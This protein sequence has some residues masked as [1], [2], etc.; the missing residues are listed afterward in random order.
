M[1]DITYIYV[2]FG[3]HIDENVDNTTRKEV[4]ALI[5]RCRKEGI[6]AFELAVIADDLTGGMMIASLLEREGV[7]CPVITETSQLEHI[8]PS[9][10]AVVF[11]NKFRLIPAPQAQETVRKA[12]EAFLTAGAKRLYYKYCATFDSTDKGNI[13]PCGETLMEV[14]GAERMIFSPSWPEWEVTVYQGHMFLGPNL[15]SNTQKIHDPVTPM[16]DSN[17]VN[18]LQRQTKVKVGLLS[19]TALQ[20]GLSASKAS[21][22]EQAADGKQ[23]FIVDAAD[24]DD[25]MQCAKLVIDWPCISGGDAMPGFLAK[26]WRAKKEKE[27]KP[28]RYH[29]PPASGYE[30]ILGGSCAAA[31]L[32]QLEYFEKQHPLFRVDLLEAS[33]NPKMVKSILEWAKPRMNEGPIAIATSGTVEQVAQVQAVLGT[34]GAALLADTVT[35]E[36]AKGLYELGARR[37][38]VAGG[39]TSGQV[40]NALGIKKVEVSSFDS[41]GG[42]YCHA[43]EPSPMTLLLKAGAIAG[44]DLFIRGLE[45]MR[46]DEQPEQNDEGVEAAGTKIEL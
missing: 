37:F 44:E 45:R 3:V 38:V 46:S 42:G 9:T 16:T 31:T 12:A 11:A 15:L 13:G 25:V 34:E 17:L 40:F 30:V 32:R 33:R 22:E 24:D 39:E 21:I 8:D 4:S 20:G 6:M 23:F 26:V 7:T 2:C 27:E 14:T 10:E 41:F 43:E 36:V 18:V 1:S 29:L 19:H 35:G 28:L 5:H